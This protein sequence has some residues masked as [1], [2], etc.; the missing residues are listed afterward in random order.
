[1]NKYKR[2]SIDEREEISRM[3]AQKCSF[4][5]IAIS[6]GRNVSTISREVGAGSCNKY[7]YFAK[8]L[9]AT[10]CLQNSNTLVNKY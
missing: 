1:M 6:L 4:Q 2:L 3:F 5:S 8:S 9:L 7:T 10:H